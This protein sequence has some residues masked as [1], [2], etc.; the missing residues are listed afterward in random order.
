[1]STQTDKTQIGL[2]DQASDHLDVVRREG[3]FRND[4]DVYRLAITIAIA[5]GLSPTPEN[6]QRTN[7]YSVGSLDPKHAMST[8]IRHL[9]DDH[10]DRPV[11]L[12]ERLAEAGL[13]RLFDHVDSGK[14]LHELLATFAPPAPES[15]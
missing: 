11:A 14:S 9:R 13:K 12:M 7:K 2:S 8:A 15:G 3:G 1:M 10:A 4:Q 5:E 6:V